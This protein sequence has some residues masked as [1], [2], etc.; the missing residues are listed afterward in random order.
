MANNP[1]AMAG[2]LQND[3]SK[4]V[5]QYWDS[6]VQSGNKS[7]KLV[8]SGQYNTKYKQAQQAKDINVKHRALEMAYK[9]LQ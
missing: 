4:K 9:K 2:D 6:T 5:C 8:Q 1:P 7:G 3:C